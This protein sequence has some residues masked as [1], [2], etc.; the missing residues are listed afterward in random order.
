MDAEQAS[1]VPQRLQ[2]L[3]QAAA[4]QLDARRNSEHAFVETLNRIARLDQALQKGGRLGTVI[5]HV[6]SGGR[7]SGTEERKHGPIGAS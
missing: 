2:L 5:G 3:E 4:E 7:T 1:H 6:F